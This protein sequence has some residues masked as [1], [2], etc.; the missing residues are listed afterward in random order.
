[1]R[2]RD[3]GI[4]H[5]LVALDVGVLSVVGG[6]VSRH[7]ERIAVFLPHE[8][9]RPVVVARVFLHPPSLE[10]GGLGEFVRT[11]RSRPVRERLLEIAVRHHRV[12]RRHV[13]VRGACRHGQGQRAAF[14]LNRLHVRRNR[15]HAHKP[16][17]ALRGRAG[18][19]TGCG[20]Q[21]RAAV[22]CRG[23]QAFTGRNSKGHVLGRIR[24][25][26]SGVDAQFA[27][28]RRYVHVRHG[29]R[30]RPFLYAFPRPLERDRRQVSGRRHVERRR[31]TLG[32]RNGTAGRRGR[33][34]PPLLHEPLAQ[35][36]SLSRGK[37]VCEHDQLVEEIASRA[38]LVLVVRVKAVHVAG[39]ADIRPGAALHLVHV[40]PGRHRRGV[41]L[42][43][44]RT[45]DEQQ[46]RAAWT[47]PPMVAHPDVRLPRYTKIRVVVVVDAVP[48]VVAVADDVGIAGVLSVDPE[49][50]ADV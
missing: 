9:A 40:K 24:M 5:D 16:R 1:M 46:A 23:R 3:P 19:D 38:V 11:A 49:N 34:K 27:A 44:I 14:H 32:N 15:L 28:E 22:A 7:L 37:N 42:R 33:Q 12:A 47:A 6:H 8:A 35:L 48:P 36:L 20:R 21:K 4:D 39:I 43:D 2:E 17:A 26:G 18:R 10:G 30:P 29:Q 50:V 45:V 13:V 31:R 25:N 41:R